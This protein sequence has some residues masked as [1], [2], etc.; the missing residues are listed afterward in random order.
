MSAIGLFTRFAGRLIR[1][2]APKDQIGAVTPSGSCLTG[3]LVRNH[4]LDLGLVSFRN[5][6]GHIGLTLLLGALRSQDVAL[7]S[8]AALYPATRRLLK[9]L[10]GAAMRLHFNLWH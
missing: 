7:E 1:R 10:G 2:Q 9:A 5:H 8:V 6:G 4:P 3:K